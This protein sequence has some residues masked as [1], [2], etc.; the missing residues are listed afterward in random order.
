MFSALFIR[1][2]RKYNPD[3]LLF[4][5]LYLFHGR[6][7]YLIAGIP[8]FLIR[9]ACSDKFNFGYTPIYFIYLGITLFDYRYR[10]TVPRL[11][12]RTNIRKIRT[13]LELLPE[14]RTALFQFGF[15]TSDYCTWYCNAKFKLEQKSRPGWWIKCT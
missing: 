1:T 7:H 10:R 12:V 8:V 11:N 2:Q 9:A 15:F 6:L 14:N 13:F 4:T 5:V 3:I